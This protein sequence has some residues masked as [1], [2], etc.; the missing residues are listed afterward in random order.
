MK[1][2]QELVR[3]NI[4][5]LEPY[6]SARDEYKGAAATVFLDANESPYNAPVNRYPDPL[7]GEVKQLL[8]KVK[9]VDVEEM[10]LGNGSDE[11]IDLVFRCFCM[12]GVDNVVAMAPTYG[13][14][15][16]CADINDVEYRSVLID[17]KF[18]I[19]AQKMLE[20]ADEHT[21]VIFLCSPNNPTGNR[22]DKHEVYS[23]IQQ[24]QGIVV[25]DEAYIDF[26]S[27]PSFTAILKKCPNLIILQTFSKAW[28]CAGMRLGIA[29]ASPEI[30]SLF[31]K[32]KYP[33]NVNILTQEK[34]KEILKNK[35]D[36]DRWVHMIL[37]ERTSLMAAFSTLPV[38]QKVY[39]TDSNFFL[40][41]MTDAP[42][43]Y[44]YLVGKGIIVRN[45]SRIILCENC[46]RITIGTKAENTALLA[47]LRNYPMK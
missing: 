22:L 17:E 12:P 45:R 6:S 19:S 30:I 14:Y 43:I 28:A 33:Y 37:E 47:A 23:L 13:M 46:L 27:E 32:V 2:L 36:V 11:A 3:P 20:A 35:A 5:A 15:K 41:R 31:N 4:W 38:T 39:P 18:Q 26:S 21:K 44:N 1:A 34:A 24:F 42:T 16:V 40:A 8:A 9:G 29:M 10:F 7:Q 25:L